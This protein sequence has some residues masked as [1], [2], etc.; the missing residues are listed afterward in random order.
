MT[1]ININN[2]DQVIGYKVILVFGFPIITEEKF[3]NEEKL[4]EVMS[5]FNS[6]N[7]PTINNVDSIWGTKVQA[8]ERVKEIKNKLF[9]IIQQNKEAI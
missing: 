5:F 4:Q 8:L 2:K 9:K 7:S 6:E 1:I 3:L